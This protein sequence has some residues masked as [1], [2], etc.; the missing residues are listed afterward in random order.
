MTFFSHLTPWPPLLKER[1]EK[2]Y[3]GDTPRPPAEGFPSA[4]PFDMATT[5]MPPAEI[6]SCLRMTIF[7]FSNPLVLIWG[8]IT[9][10]PAEIA[11]LRSQ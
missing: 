11:S 7:I 1:G 4:L 3:L 10:P 5:P 6:L 9:R 8:D 2:K